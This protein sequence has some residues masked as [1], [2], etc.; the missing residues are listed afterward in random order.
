MLS[1]A[2]AIARTTY[3]RGFAILAYVKAT[4]GMIGLVVVGGMPAEA[5]A[6]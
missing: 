4:W 2:T 1:S 3:F 5:P 6:K